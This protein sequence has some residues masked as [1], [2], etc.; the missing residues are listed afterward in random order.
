MTTPLVR[1]SVCILACGGPLNV[2][3]KG[4][5]IASVD[6]T[7][8]TQ[9]PTIR[10]GLVSLELRDASG[11]RV[12]TMVWAGPVVRD[13]GPFDGNMPD[14]GTLRLWVPVHLDTPLPVLEKAAPA[15]FVGEVVVSGARVRI[16]GQVPP[17]G[18]TG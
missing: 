9:A 4:N 10:V 12:A 5:A 11:R 2:D 7:I 1:G 14:A 13:A 6:L 8:E 18:S 15:Q 16:S 17:P 3:D